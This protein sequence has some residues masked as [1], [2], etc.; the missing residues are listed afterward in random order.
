MYSGN[1]RVSPDWAAS[2]NVL[3]TV[4]VSRENEGVGCWY[5]QP[6]FALQSATK[7]LPM[8]EWLL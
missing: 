5:P 1:S 8:M 3:N 7:Q 4:A 2:N 6:K